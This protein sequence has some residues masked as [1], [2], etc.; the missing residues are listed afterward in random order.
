VATACKTFSATFYELV[1]CQRANGAL[2]TFSDPEVAWRVRFFVRYWQMPCGEMPTVQEGYVF[3]M[4]TNDLYDD[5]DLD[6]LQRIAIRN[7]MFSGAV[8]C[9]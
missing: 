4:V 9:R 5:S 3:H 2:N 8:R 7:A 6:N 1:A